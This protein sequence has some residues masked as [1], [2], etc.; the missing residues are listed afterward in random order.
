VHAGAGT[1]L[2]TKFL[3]LGQSIK[4]ILIEIMPTLDFC[5]QP[6]FV[7]KP[8]TC[9][10]MPDFHDLASSYMLELAQDSAQNV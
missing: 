3:K 7:G 5:L 1:R 6:Y 8:R 9:H 10:S 4:H 2:W